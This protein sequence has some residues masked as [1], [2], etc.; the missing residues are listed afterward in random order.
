MQYNL[1]HFTKVQNGGDGVP[2]VALK[3]SLK[4]FMY[5]GK[6]ILFFFFF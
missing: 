5:K 3:Y 2:Q 4:E 6:Y 1:E